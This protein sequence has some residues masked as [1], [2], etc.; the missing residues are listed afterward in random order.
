MSYCFVLGMKIYSDSDKKFPKRSP[1]IRQKRQVYGDFNSRTAHQLVSRKR[2]SSTDPKPGDVIDL[3][4]PSGQ[5]L[6]SLAATVAVDNS[7][8]NTHQD[9]GNYCT[10]CTYVAYIMIPY[11]VVCCYVYVY[12]VRK[13]SNMRTLL[14]VV[15]MTF[16]CHWES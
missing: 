5:S 16:L 7:R 3:K 4:K 11:V 1:P 14:M 2:A 6:A 10:Y 12:M 9:T 8:T 15:F 13:N